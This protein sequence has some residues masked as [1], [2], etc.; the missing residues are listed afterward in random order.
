[1]SLFPG[2]I[3]SGQTHRR[4][5]SA[6]VGRR[7]AGLVT[8]AIAGAALVAFAA[9]GCSSDT[10]SST[11]SQPRTDP[12]TNAPA[13]ATVPTA[14]PD[15]PPT[16]S[17]SA[18]ADV[19]L[20]LPDKIGP[21]TK[22]ADQSL[23]QSLLSGAKD[24]SGATQNQAASYE[25]RSNKSHTVLVYGGTGNVPAGSPDEQVDALLNAFTTD[26]AKADKPTKVSAGKVG[27]T[28]KCA[29]GP[30]AHGPYNCVWVKGRTAVLMSFQNYS[31]NAAQALVAT[32]LAATV[33]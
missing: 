20:R 33:R 10:P 4:I 32:I 3:L 13:T 2:G 18:A 29:K 5:G 25:D 26:A 15:G 28:S 31:P 6:A 17:G 19:T 8:R 16:P 7:R 24:P 27:G 21:L 23:A 22:S 14:T 9:A 30:A 1:M 12:S 11:P